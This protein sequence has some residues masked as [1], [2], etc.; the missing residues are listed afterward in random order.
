MHKPAMHEHMGKYLPWLEQVILRKIKR[1]VFKEQL[2]VTNGQCS[3]EHQDIDNK[4]MLNG[5]CK[6][7]HGFK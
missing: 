5:I 2:P 6:S 7:D 4:Q 3:K 1:K